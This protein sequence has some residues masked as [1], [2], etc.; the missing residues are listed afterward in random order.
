MTGAPTRRSAHAAPKKRRALEINALALMTSTV[1]TGV[2]GLVFW[3][4]AARVLPPTAVG[5]ASSAL[6]AITFLA[7]LAQLNI[8][9]VLLRFVPGAGRT[10]GTFIA[11]AYGLA[12]AAA[13]VAALVFVALGFGREILG[14]GWLVGAFFVAGTLCY[15]LFLV[16]DGAL[17]SLGAAVWVPLENLLAGAL[18][19]GMLFALVPISTRWGAL[20]ALVVPT[21]VAVAVVNTYVFRRLVPRH[22]A[23]ATTSAELDWRSMRGFVAGDYAASALGSCVSLLPPVLVASQL[24]SEAAAYFYIPWFI[25]VSFGTLVWSIAMA[26]VVEYAGDASTFERLMRRSFRLTA[27]VSVSACVVVVLGAPLLLSL[28]GSDYADEGATTLRLIALAF[29]FS[30]G[31][32]LFTAMSL[33]RKKL[34]PLVASLAVKTAVFLGVAL[35]WL[36][37]LGVNGLAALYLA[38]EAVTAL[39]MLPTALRFHRALVDQGHVAVPV[40]VP[41]AAPVATPAATPVADGGGSA[42]GEGDPAGTP[43]ASSR[44]SA[45]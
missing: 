39:A 27:L 12:L 17:T 42:A 10:T 45:P 38:C 8:I 26:F 15:A 9:S 5:Q 43:P 13:L 21:F 2:L 32:I 23:K 7:G 35:V 24:G 19:V 4:V 36:P 18:R 30:A 3:I 33:A 41:V 29:P 16:Q 1:F 14:E 44:E 6:S 37:D 34:T 11:R 25:G 20:G 40:A 22:E 31:F 28:L